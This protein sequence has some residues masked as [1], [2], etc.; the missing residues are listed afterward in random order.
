ML[1]ISS[2]ENF[3]SGITPSDAKLLS[4]YLPGAQNSPFMPL[5]LSMSATNYGK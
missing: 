4:T 3:Q 5:G 1:A 2:P